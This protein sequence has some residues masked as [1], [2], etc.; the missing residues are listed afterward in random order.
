MTSVPV[1]GEDGSVGSGPVGPAADGSP[2]AE[3]SRVA[4]PRSISRRG[5]LRAAGL[6]AAVVPASAALAACG[7][8]SNTSTGARAVRIGFVTP[9][10]GALSNYSSSDIYTIN[11]MQASFAK[12]IRV[13]DQNH[14]LE[15]IYRDSQSDPN[16]AAIVASDLI[17]KDNVDIML[18]G[19]SSATTNPVS[20]QC[21]ANQVPCIST[22]APWESWFN[23]RGGRLGRNFT[24]TF[25]VFWG[26]DDLAKVYSDMWQLETTDRKIGLLVPND[27]DGDT[28]NSTLPN[29]ISSLNGFTIPT[30]VAT[31]YNDGSADLS[32]MPAAMAGAGIDILAGVP[33]VEDFATF[34]KAST[35]AAGGNAHTFAPK[36]VTLSRALLFPND[37]LNQLGTSGNGLAT[38]VG[39]SPSHPYRSSITGASPKQLAA[40]YNKTT[41]QE[42]VQPLGFTHALFEVVNRALASVHSIDDKA[43]IAKAIGNVRNLNSIVG[44]LAFGNGGRSTNAVPA[45][46]AKTPLVGGQWRTS[47]QAGASG[48]SLYIT[49]NREHSD[50]AL[51]GRYT[52][53]TQ[54]AAGA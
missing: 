32:R 10:T 23:G 50:I 27:T 21:E 30:S 34:W 53:L 19:G 49:S 2:V 52:P 37:V 16:S 35:L 40:D 7:G 3:V 39:W 24:W 6:T 9:Q 1:S 31:R 41:G 5:L 17:F 14:P 25:H 22:A 48:Y 43:S 18:V 28:F 26:L 44:P 8:G 45:N 54:I 29:V 42:W 12:G 46:V 20:D 47:T 4:V 11:A 15:I 13:G 51:T 36:I 38:E 33:L